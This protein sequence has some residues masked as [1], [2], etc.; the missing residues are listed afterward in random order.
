MG[1]GTPVPST[2][3]RQVS[4]LV[5]VDQINGDQITVYFVEEGQRSMKQSPNL[6]LYPDTEISQFQ[7]IQLAA[8]KTKQN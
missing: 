1:S 2:S 4:I 8:F 7:K 3:L 5:N 6:T